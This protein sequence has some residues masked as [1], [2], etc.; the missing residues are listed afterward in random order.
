[1]ALNDD[2]KPKVEEVK[3]IE[4]PTKVEIKDNNPEVIK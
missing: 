4:K 1:V 3:V 2:I